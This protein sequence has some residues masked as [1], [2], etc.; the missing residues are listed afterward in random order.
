MKIKQV[1][2][3]LSQSSWLPLFSWRYLSYFIN[4]LRL[5]AKLQ[6]SVTNSKYVWSC[7]WLSDWLITHRF[8]QI[9]SSSREFYFHFY[10]TPYFTL[11]GNRKICCHWGTSGY[12]NL[13]AIKKKCIVLKLKAVESQFDFISKNMISKLYKTTLK[14]KIMHKIIYL[15]Y[16]SCIHLHPFNVL[17]TGMAT[18]I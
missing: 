13:E 7:W 2:V 12:W 1:E 4:A 16:I 11:I 8:H 18:L 9:R 17:K 14:L 10:V 5:F 3:K 6:S 15:H